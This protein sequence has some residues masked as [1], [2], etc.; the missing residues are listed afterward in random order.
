[1]GH[2]T[3]NAT[4]RNA[5]LRGAVSQYRLGKVLRQSTHV[6]ILALR[7]VYRPDD[8]NE[9]RE[10][11]LRNSGNYYSPCPDCFGLIFQ[12][13]YRTDATQESTCA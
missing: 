5:D 4:G 6:R 1:M 10:S 11:D 3:G 12:A 8:F 7:S 2:G 9:P 13:L